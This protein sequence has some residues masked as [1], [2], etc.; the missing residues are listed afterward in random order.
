MAQMHV[1]DSAAL[2]SLR[3]QRGGDRTVRRAPGHDQQIASGSPIGHDV[4]NVLRDRRHFRRAQAHHLLVVQR[5]VVDVAGD[6]LLFESADAVLKPGVPGIAHG[7]ASVSGSR[8]YGW[9]PTG[10]VSKCT[11]N[12]RNLVNVRNFATARRRLPDSR[13]KE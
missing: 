6:V 5:L 11:G 12:F 1:A 10:F 9:K 7:R 8:R 2:G 3:I 13:P 4:G